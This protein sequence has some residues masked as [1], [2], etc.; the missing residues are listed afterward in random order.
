MNDQEESF[1]YL[2]GFAGVDRAADGGGQLVLPGHES[3][4]LPASAGRK[5]RKPLVWEPVMALATADRD[6]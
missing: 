6:L 3:P 2:S 4:P 5:N 1:T